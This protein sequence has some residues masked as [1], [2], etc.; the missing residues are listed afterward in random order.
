MHP[1]PDFVATR[2]ADASEFERLL[3]GVANASAA[4]PEAKAAVAAVIRSAFEAS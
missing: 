4:T 3:L 1:L 2:R